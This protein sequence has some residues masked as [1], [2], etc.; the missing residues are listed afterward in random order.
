ME[1]FD[2]EGRL[3]FPKKPDGR[4]QIRRYLDEREGTPVPTLWDDIRPINSQAQERLGYPTQKPRALLERIISASSNPGDVVLDPFCGCGTAVDAAEK[5][6]RR[7]I[8]ID[9]THLA[10]GMIESRLRD[11]YEGIQ[12]ETIGVP[13]DLASAERLAA[14]DPHQFQQWVCWQAGGFP[15]DKKGGDKG[16]DGW[17]N[18]LAAKNSIKTG[19]ISVKAGDNVNPAMVRDLGQV[20][21]RD[22][23][24]FGLFICKSL[25]TKGM[26]AEAASHP[27]V[28]T[29]FGTFPALQ[30]VTLADFFHGP[31]PK[32]PPLISPVKKASRV[33]IRASHQPGAQGGLAL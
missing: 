7:W 27:M 14:D 6:G 29:E 16:V 24:A 18:Y 26:E 25:P 21:K 10:I 11:G 22:G 3:E 30:L 32:L 23:H 5:L 15:R 8:G 12:F 9:I 13:K 20:M 4:I 2:R 17:F 19:V 1:Q 28:E 31:G 33:E